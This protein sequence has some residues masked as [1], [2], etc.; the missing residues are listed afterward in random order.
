MPV[1]QL[2]MEVVSEVYVLTEK[3]PKKE[4]YA[5]SGQMR[6][7]AISIAGN[8]AEG[9][10]RNHTKDKLNFYFYSR[11]SATEEISHL[12]CGNKV[13]YFSNDEVSSINQ[14]CRQIIEGLNKLIKSL[15]AISAST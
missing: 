4:D 6:A 3:L 14:K 11:G 13:G 8:I 9:F 1:W 5:L 10:G 12:L 15:R 7:A 2:S